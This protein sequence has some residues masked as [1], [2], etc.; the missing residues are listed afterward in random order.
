M[1]RRTFIAGASST[2]PLLAGLPALAADGSIPARKLDRISIASSTFRAKFDGWQYSVP[3]EMPRLS[4]LTLPAYVR[5]R[6]GVR[7]L[8]LWGRQFGAEGHTEEHYRK[9]RAAADAA[10]VSIVNLQ[11]EDLPSLNA[12]DEAARAEVLAALKVWLDKAK[13]LGAGSIRIN[14]TRQA[15]PINLEAVI[16]LLRAGAAYGRSIGVRILLENHGG[17]T[18]II[19][20]LISLVKAVNDDFVRITIDWGAWAPPGPPNDRYEAM[21]SAMPL[22]H[23]VSAKGSEFDPVTYEHTTF[24]VARLVRNAE[25]GGFRGVYSIEFFGNNPPKDTDA[26]VRR[27]IKTIT[28]NMA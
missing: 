2:V 8:E 19:P 1:R 23:I 25:A 17:Y 26:A 15:G 4:L 16:A 20:D 6:F 28:D 3:T 18:Q 27:F 12:G 5:D 9:I 24:D 14:V 21:Q 10:G 22:V 7:K 11:V 13:I